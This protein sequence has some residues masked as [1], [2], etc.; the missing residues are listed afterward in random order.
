MENLITESNAEKVADFLK[1]I[2]S[3][4]RLL[5]LC[6][7]SQ[8]EKSAGQLSNDLH[9]APANLS[10]HLSKLK[11]AGLVASRRD[12]TSIHYRLT[13]DKVSALVTVLGQ[14]QVTSGAE[15][16]YVN[17]VASTHFAP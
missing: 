8:G 9:V 2:A 6:E 7:L 13:S 16:G 14:I 5:V 10:Q 4:H 15:A 3:R 17:D 11:A 12:G 1:S